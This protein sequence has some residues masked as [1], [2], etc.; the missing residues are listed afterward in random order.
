MGINI[1]MNIN[2]TNTKQK[3]DELHTQRLVGELGR[4]CKYHT[5]PV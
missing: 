4:S 5:K 2:M 1:Y 3:L